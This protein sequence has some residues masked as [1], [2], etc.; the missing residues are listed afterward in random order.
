[1]GP[2]RP[3][4]WPTRRAPHAHHR[5]GRRSAPSTSA[6]PTWCCSWP[7]PTRSTSRSTVRL[8]GAPRIPHGANVHFVAPTAGRGRRAAPCGCGSGVPGVTEACGTGACAAAVAGTRLGPASAPRS[9]CRCPAATSSVSLGDTVPAHRARRSGSP[10][11]RCP[12]DRSRRRAGPGLR[13]RASSF[14][15]PLD[16]VGDGHDEA[17]DA[18]PPRCVRRARR[19]V[20]ARSSSAR[21]GSASC[22]SAW[23]PAARRSTTSRPTSTS[24][25]ASSTPPAPTPSPGSCSAATA[26]TRPPTSAR[27][28]SRSCATVAEAID[29]DTVVFDDE[30]SPAQQR[31]LEKLLGRTAIDRTAVILDIF[32]QNASSQEG[33]AQVELA[34]LRYRLP[35]LRGKGQGLS[36]QGGRHRHPAGWRRDQARGRPSPH[37]PAHP[38]ARGRAAR[39]R[40]APRHAAQGPQPQPGPAGRHRRLHQRRQVHLAQP[41]HRRRRARRGP[42]VRHPRRHHPAAPAARRRGGAAHRHG[43]A[44]SA[45]CPTGSSRRSSPRSTSSSRPTC[46]STWSTARRSTPTR[47]IAAVRDVLAEI[48]ADQVPE[49]LCV[50]KLDLGRSRHGVDGSDADRARSSARA[51]STPTPDRSASRRAPASG[52]DDAA[53]R[54]RRPAAG[55]HRR[56]RARS[57]P[58]TAA[59]CSP[60]CTAR[61][62]CCRR[63]PSD[64]GMRLRARLDDAA[65]GR[66]HDIVVAPA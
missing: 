15:F 38:P 24:S 10:T 16:P 39:H 40:P 28:R 49:L 32:A 41:A 2:A 20:R 1:M 31:N 5:G 9:W 60:R 42:A 13:R 4:R 36:Q 63:R 33:K 3:G 14:E 46:S 59:T 7:I 54:H 55:P 58:T 62:R 17:L 29:C 66:F 51:C 12:R 19:R 47:E 37:R 25:P 48:G 64:D 35:R 65:V 11:S 44:S 26:P 27:A 21:S 56:G 50:N 22:S 45:S 6:T 53:P 43:R 52:I 34:L 30:L 8:L 61:A 18:T 57:C 23:P